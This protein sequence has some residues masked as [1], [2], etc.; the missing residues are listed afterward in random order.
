M[1]L[2]HCSIRGSTITNVLPPVELHFV[3]LSTPPPGNSFKLSCF[4]EYLCLGMISAQYSK[5]ELQQPH[6]G[7]YQGLLC[8][9]GPLGSLHGRLARSFLQFP[10]LPICLYRNNEKALKHSLNFIQGTPFSPTLQLKAWSKRQLTDITI[11]S[12]AF[13]GKNKFWPSFPSVKSL[14]YS[15]GIERINASKIHI[16]FLG[17]LLLPAIYLTDY[18]FYYHVNCSRLQGKKKKKY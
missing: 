15:L 2:Q 6:P 16:F 8:Y 10:L 3:L 12:S 11:R 17:T 7:C 5:V 14:R 4:H 1:S 9:K 18:A 13:N